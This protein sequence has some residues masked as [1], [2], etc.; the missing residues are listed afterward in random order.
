MNTVSVTRP[1]HSIQPCSQHH[2]IEYCSV[3]KGLVKQI[4]IARE[5]ERQRRLLTIVMFNYVSRTIFSPV[6]YG[7]NIN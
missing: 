4:I 2:F 6:V 5:T 7:Q 1:F 3:S